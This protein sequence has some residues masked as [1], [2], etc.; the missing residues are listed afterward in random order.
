MADLSQFHFC[1]IDEVVLANGITL[2]CGDAKLNQFFNQ[3]CPKLRAELL[4]NSYCFLENAEMVCAFSISNTSI[5]VDNLPNSRKKKVIKDIPNQKRFKSYPAILIG[6]LAVSENYKGRGIGRELLDFI[7]TF[8]IEKV[9]YYSAARF[10]VVDAYNKEDV[11]P[12]YTKC[13]FDFV[14]STEDQ[15]RVNNG[16]ASEKPL[17]T[18]LM[19]YDLI[20]TTE[21]PSGA[22]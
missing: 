19:Y 3:D 16:T 4:A 6:Q 15:E 12:F 5:K 17:N 2:D 13:N 14:F 21:S 7:L 1:P 11:L 20:N 22:I 10:I 8:V 18:R 9:N